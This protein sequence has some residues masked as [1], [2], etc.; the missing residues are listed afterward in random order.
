MWLCRSRVCSAS[1]NDGDNRDSPR[2]DVDSAQHLVQL[3][4]FENL[5]QD[6]KIPK[7]NELQT[8]VIDAQHCVDRCVVKVET[9]PLTSTATAGVLRREHIIN[10]N[11]AQIQN[12]LD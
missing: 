3:E 2:S 5:N 11:W 12:S 4:P 10:Q 7:H 6:A 8:N 1:N 9:S